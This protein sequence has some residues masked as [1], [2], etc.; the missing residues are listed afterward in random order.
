ML[1]P[2][3]PRAPWSASTLAAKRCACALAGRKGR[4]T[5][6]E[7]RRWFFLYGV[8]LRFVLSPPG[9]LN[10][11]L[12][13]GVLSG[14]CGRSFRFFA[15]VFLAFSTFGT[16][17]DGPSRN[18]HRSIHIPNHHPMLG[19][20]GHLVRGAR[21]TRPTFMAQLRRVR[22]VYGYD[23]A[24]ILRHVMSEP[25]HK[26]PTIPPAMPHRVSK[27]AQIFHGDN[28]ITPRVGQASYLLRRENRKL[29]LLPGRR[30][31]AKPSL[32]QRGHARLP[33]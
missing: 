31:T 33:P 8:D 16:A 4:I 29:T 9:Y 23:P 6:P 21:N 26:L 14:T 3:A 24:A 17:R 1:T 19:A 28:G 15:R 30:L 13:T 7:T 22:R 20:D 32:I 10:E 25:P 2:K 27:P 18:I 12:A 11:F 5:S